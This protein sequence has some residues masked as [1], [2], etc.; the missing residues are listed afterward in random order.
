MFSAVDYSGPTK[1][2]RL[3]HVVHHGLN[4]ERRDTAKIMLF[5][6]LISSNNSSFYWQHAPMINFRTH[7]LEEWAK[8]TDMK[9][10]AELVVLESKLLN[11]KSSTI[12]ES[13]R[14]A[15]IEMGTTYKEWGKLDESLKCFLRSRDYCSTPHHHLDCAFN[16]I[17]T[18]INS[19][20]RFNALNFVNKIQDITTESQYVAKANCIQGLLAVMDKQF[21]SASSKFLCV[22]CNVGNDLAEIVIGKDI[23]LYAT[24]SF[25][26]T[27]NRVQLNDI[28]SSHK[29]FVKYY[30]N[31]DP[32]LKS[33]LQDVTNGKYSEVK[34]LLEFIKDRIK[35]DAYLAEQRETI[36]F[37]ILDH[38]LAEYL[39]PYELVSLDQVAECFGMEMKLIE[40][41]IINMIS[42]G[43][44][45]AKINS[46]KG[47]ISKLAEDVGANTVHE[48]RL[49]MDSNAHNLLR[50][51]I[52]CR[53]L[54]ESIAA[55]STRPEGSK[56]LF[57]EQYAGQHQENIEAFHEIKS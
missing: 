56:R 46:K 38:L 30:L 22:D 13:I 50:N 29:N 53:V 19:D 35:E 52:R 44:I 16:V 12:K 10:K 18:S 49:L 26:I 2:I 33:Y 28:W 1:L 21:S 40:N 43:K 25:L 7:E 31:L 39:K 24:I 9:L 8:L 48:F 41:R 42:A 6:Q 17:V 55:D 15:Y 57:V 37:S 3:L 20:Q 51:V 27:F 36:A 32:Q 5:D 23:A 4:E 47:V 45:S 34:R 14:Q 11:A 54:S